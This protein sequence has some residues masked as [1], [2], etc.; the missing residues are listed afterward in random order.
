MNIL[1]IYRHFWPDTTPYARMLRAILERWVADGHSVMVYTAQPNYNDVRQ[2]KQA[3]RETLN[4]VQIRRIGLLPE[5]KRFKMLRG[6]NFSC[7]LLRAAL[8]VLCHRKY[9]LIV[10]NTHPPVLMG[11]ALR[12]IKRLTGI[13]YL[14]HCQDVHPESAV[15]VGQLKEGWL[16]RRLLAND[17]KSCRDARTVVTLS[18]DMRE[19]LANRTGYS[20]ENVRII[21]NF[22]LDR[23]GQPASIPAVFH[24]DPN[25]PFRVLFAGNMGLFQNLERL[26]AAAQLLQDEPEIQFVFMGAGI[27]RERLIEQA[28]KLDGR[29]VH[30]EPFQPVETAFACMQQSNL[31]IVSLADGVHRVAYPSKT[32]TYLDAG[33]PVLALVERHCNL[34]EDILTNDFGYVAAGAAIERVAD[35]IRAAYKDRHR[36]TAKAR[37]ALAKRSNSYFGRGRALAQWSVLLESLTSKQIELRN[38]TQQRAA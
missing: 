17:V 21:N 9:D 5:H 7:F 22:P 15:L 6:V 32:M 19:Q 23:Y 35:V 14:L 4:G 34:S 29:T 36:W 26:I 27:A 20:A 2:P 16:F 30:F 33:C 8:H 25:R 37:R 28:G 10:A 18:A 11:V 38:S 13:P 3:T 1:A 12:L 24:D 31:G